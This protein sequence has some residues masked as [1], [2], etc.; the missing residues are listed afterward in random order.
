MTPIISK[1]NS[2]IQNALPESCRNYLKTAKDKVSSCYAT[3][4]DSA[5][6]TSVWL[7]ERETSP[8]TSF[9]KGVLY[10]VTRPLTWGAQTVFAATSPTPNPQDTIQKAN[11]IA[12]EGLN[13]EAAKGSTIAPEKSLIQRLLKDNPSQ[14][15]EDWHGKI[16]E[17][18]KT[19]VRDLSAHT[20]LTAMYSSAGFSDAGTRAG[21]DFLDLVQKAATAPNVSLWKLFKDK[22]HPT[23]F[24]KLKAGFVYLIYY[25]GLM[26]STINT[27]LSSVIDVLKK[28]LTEENDETRNKLFT[29]ILDNLYTYLLRHFDATKDFS[30]RVVKHDAEGNIK[31]TQEDLRKFYVEELYNFDIKPICELFSKSLMEAA[32]SV[33]VSLLP[34]SLKNLFFIGRVFKFV[35]WVLNQGI[36]K[37][38]GHKLPN[39]LKDSI[40]NGIEFTTP[41]NLPFAIFIVEFLKDQLIKENQTKGDI[42]SFESSKN[43]TTVTISREK[44]GKTIKQLKTIIALSPYKDTFELKREIKKLEDERNDSLLDGITES[45]IHDTI[46]ESTDLL[47]KHLNN[48]ARSG[49]LFHVLLEASS[50]IFENKEKNLAVLQ[51]TFQKEKNAL[52]E[53]ASIAFDQLLDLEVPKA[54]NN[55]ADSQLPLWLKGTSEET[56][57]LTDRLVDKDTLAK[58]LSLRAIQEQIRTIEHK[59]AQMDVNAS[60]D[61]S[62]QIQE[63]LQ[64]LRDLTCRKDLLSQEN[65]QTPEDLIEG[66]SYVDQDALRRQ[67]HGFYEKI[68]KLLKNNLLAFQKQQDDQN[69]Y[70]DTENKLQNILHLC[71]EIKNTNRLENRHQKIEKLLSS[72]PFPTE[73]HLYESKLKETQEAVTKTSKNITQEQSILQSLDELSPHLQDL[74]KYWQNR[75]SWRYSLKH[76]LSQ[77]DR[78]IDRSFLKPIEKQLLKD[79]IRKNSLIDKTLK[80]IRARRQMQIDLYKAKILAL[81]PANFLKE[82]KTLSTK[83]RNK[84]EKEIRENV[85]DLSIQIEELLA[86]QKNLPSPIAP[87]TTHLKELT[88]A[89]AAAAFGTLLGSLAHPSIAGFTGTLFSLGSQVVWRTEPNLADEPD[90]KNRLPDLPEDPEKRVDEI[91]RNIRN[92]KIGFSAN[93]VASL[94][95]A[96]ALPLISSSLTRSPEAAFVLSTVGATAIAAFWKNK[97]I[98]YLKDGQIAPKVQKLFH[99]AVDLCLDPTS[100]IGRALV[101]GAILSGEKLLREG[102]ANS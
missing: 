32:S 6:K 58:N 96:F 71:E 87:E 49:E 84:L 27:Y 47:F 95:T 9:I 67:L 92:A 86:E 14:A 10:P 13:I 102:K 12:K 45:A 46:I 5:V 53:Q 29:I 3:I 57:I 72:L 31:I 17:V 42:Y 44:L 94:A 99:G 65:I 37:Y 28:K 97:A 91:N 90:K 80:E 60:I 101:N 34:E 59:L 48:M 63:I 52:N 69:K 55:M 74:S 98:A 4:A 18:T 75:H 38:I 100:Y 33:S 15:Q 25:S 21:S 70:L 85:A 50:K 61:I 26:H 88:T 83:T 51:Q 23:F 43:K 81:L 41:E 30:E 76:S 89:T 78:I 11:E 64:S 39:I 20:A 1:L 24:Q 56:R 36:R 73:L 77:M 35:E 40:N 62:K 54:I 19:L 16:N 79:A 7:G 2:Q 93:N 8:N 68:A 82:V 22:Y 66:L